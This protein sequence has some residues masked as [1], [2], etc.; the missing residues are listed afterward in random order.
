MSHAHVPA[1]TASAKLFSNRHLDEMQTVNTSLLPQRRGDTWTRENRE[2]LEFNLGRELNCNS[3]WNFDW[4]LDLL[5]TIGDAVTAPL[6]SCYSAMPVRHGAR[7][8]AP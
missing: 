2:N 6:Q 5:F 1:V 7:A 8:T 3:I 4:G